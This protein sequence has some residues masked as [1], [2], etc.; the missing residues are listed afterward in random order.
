MTRAHQS[1][2]WKDRFKSDLRSVQDL[3]LKNDLRSD[4]D[5]DH[6]SKKYDLDLILGSAC[7]GVKA[8]SIELT[9]CVFKTL[10]H[11]KLYQLFFQNCNSCLQEHKKKI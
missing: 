2:P 9:N 8:V 3:R 4:Q 5:Q 1:R 6:F 11:S 7:F 10:E